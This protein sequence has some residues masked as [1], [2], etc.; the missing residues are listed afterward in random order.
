MNPRQPSRHIPGIP[1]LSEHDFKKTKEIESSDMKG[2]IS[3]EKSWT[4]MNERKSLSPNPIAYS[5]QEMPKTI[6][7]A[8]NLSIGWKKGRKFNV[9]AQDINFKAK[10][11]YLIAL[12]GPNG[13]GKSTLLKTIAGLQPPCGGSLFL[14]GKEISRISVEE[15]AQLLACVFPERIETGYLTV[16]E[17]VAFGRYPYTNARHRLTEEDRQQV[18][19]A[20]S[21]VGMENFKNRTVSS[22]SD[23]ERQKVQIARAVA[24]STALL[25]FDEPT[26]FLDAPSRIEVFR[27]A[28]RLVRQAGKTLLLCTH[29]V[30]L[31]LKTADELWVIDR[32]HH[33]SAGAPFVI[34][35]SGAIGR[36]FDLPSV[37]FDVFSGTFKAR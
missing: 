37:A 21:M 24:Q 10:E 25:I 5:S 4:G 32:A 14:M 33:F 27:L 29:E 12:V 19:E 6:L 26:A 7:E 35:R 36:A 2:G 34:A 23:G 1:D 22:L 18:M 20:L 30:D 13:A 11:G 28:E 31:A 17:L 16:W 8:N 9:L 15:R 3:I